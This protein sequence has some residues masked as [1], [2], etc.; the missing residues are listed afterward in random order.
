M[1]CTYTMAKRWLL[2]YLMTNISNV[3]KRQIYTMQN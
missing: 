3:Y 1:Q 2:S